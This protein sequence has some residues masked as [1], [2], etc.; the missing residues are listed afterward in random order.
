MQQIL[1]LLMFYLWPHKLLNND[2]K[3]VSHWK[4]VWKSWHNSDLQ[5]ISKLGWKWQVKKVPDQH[6]SWLVFVSIFHIFINK[7]FHLLLQVISHQTNQHWGESQ[8]WFEA[9]NIWKLDK[10]IKLKDFV[11]FLLWGKELQFCEALQMENKCNKTR[12]FCKRCL[13]QINWMWII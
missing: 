5:K 13:L 7:L 6:F 12:Q 3:L 4:S 10:K 9:K 8:N 1:L 11:L 2:N